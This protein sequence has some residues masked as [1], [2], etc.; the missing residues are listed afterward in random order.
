MFDVISNYTKLKCKESLISLKLW[1]R[2]TEISEINDEN[3]VPLLLHDPT[4]LLI[5]FVLNANS[6]LHELTYKYLVCFVFNLA[7]VQNMLLL[8]AKLDKKEFKNWYPFVIEV[9][10]IKIFRFKH[11]KMKHFKFLF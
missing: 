8:L 4:A 5:L 10:F 3:D 11:F 6:R 2:L 9:F 7:Y 1:S